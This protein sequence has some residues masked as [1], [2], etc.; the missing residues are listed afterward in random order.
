MAWV[1]RNTGLLGS[2]LNVNYIVQ[3]P[4]TKL[5]T[6]FGHELMIATD[7][8]VLLSKNG[9][10]TWFSF[11][12]PNPS[13]AEFGDSPAAFRGE[14]TFHWVAYDPLV[15]DT[16]YAMAAKDSVSRLWLYKSEDKGVTWT[17]RGVT[18]V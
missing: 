12:I 3:N 18:T 5:L 10:R 2:G 17:S 13:N 1:A 14:L 8:G 9:G 6:S 4:A 15:K 16:I 7:Q 11:T